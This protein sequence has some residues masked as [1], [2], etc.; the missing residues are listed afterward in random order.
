MHDGTYIVSRSTEKSEFK[1]KETLNKEVLR[2]MLA[3]KTMIKK[4]TND[5]ED[6]VLEDSA[7]ALPNTL[8]RMEFETQ[9]S[10]DI[11]V[12]AEV[13]KIWIIHD[14]D[15]NGALDFNE[16]EK[17]LTT[18]SDPKLNAPYEEIKKIFDSIDTDKSGSIDK[19]EMN[20]FITNLMLRQKNLDFKNSSEF[21]K[22]FDNI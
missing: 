10:R 11:K 17:Y 4:K 9:I 20:V 19:K 8:K 16:I 12:L 5:P 15:N 14:L 18:M 13:E 7:L 21:Y 22:S 1:Y 3:Y 2:Q 6:G